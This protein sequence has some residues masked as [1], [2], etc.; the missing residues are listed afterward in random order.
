MKALSIILGI[1]AA[2]CLI[3]GFTLAQHQLIFA[4]LSGAASAVC[5]YAYKDER[6]KKTGL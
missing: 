3:A 6:E 5:W 1:I 2:C 4:V